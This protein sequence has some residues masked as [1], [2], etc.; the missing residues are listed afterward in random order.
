[1]IP[2]HKVTS[3][4]LK[5]SLAANEKVTTQ[6]VLTYPVDTSLNTKSTQLSVG[7]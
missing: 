3:T 2:D 6:V 4:P 7:I 1:M 5:I